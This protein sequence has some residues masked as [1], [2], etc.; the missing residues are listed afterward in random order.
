M[1]ANNT[2]THTV[3]RERELDASCRSTSTEEEAANVPSHPMNAKKTYSQAPPHHAPKLV[4]RSPSTKKKEAGLFGRAPFRLR[5]L[6]RSPAKRFLG[7]AVF[8]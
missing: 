5:L 1:C 2:I 3:T 8:Q 7:G 4:A 6:Q